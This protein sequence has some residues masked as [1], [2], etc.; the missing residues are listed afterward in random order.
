MFGANENDESAGDDEPG[1]SDLASKYEEPDPESKYSDPATE[2]PNIPEAPKPLPES[3]VDTDLKVAFWSTVLV[4]NVA[5]LALSL[6]LMLVY[7]R[8]Q[9][10]LGGGLFALGVFSAAHG[11][12][13]YRKYD[14]QYGA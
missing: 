13:K 10:R 5:L 6:G 3:E 1:V 11:Y 9:L 2:L 14:D 7:F 4:F 12:L 8:G